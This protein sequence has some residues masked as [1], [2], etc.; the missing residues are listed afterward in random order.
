MSSSIN[1][2]VKIASVLGLPTAPLSPYLGFERFISDLNPG[3]LPAGLRPVGEDVAQE[4][5]VDGGAGRRVPVY[6]QA[7]AQAG[8]LL[9]QE[10]RGAAGPL[11]VCLSLEG[12]LAGAGGP[13]LVLGRH[14]EAVGGEG[15]EAGHQEP[16]LV[17]PGLDLRHLLLAVLP[18]VD[19][20]ARDGVVVVVERDGPGE[21]DRPAADPRDHRAVGRR[22][23]G[24]LHYELHRAGVQPVVD[25]AVVQPAV[26]HAH[27]TEVQAVSVPVQRPPVGVVPLGDLVIE[28]HQPQAPA[29]VGGAGAAV[30]A[31]ADP[32]YEVEVGGGGEATARHRDVA[33]GPRHHPGGGRG[34]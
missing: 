2:V 7:G 18:D 15:L 27:G 11:P 10:G 6:I 28:P 26:L 22:L 24:V 29:G 32:L 1:I 30:A 13:D 33:A 20:V 3:S 31:A 8:D 12:L 23:G 17:P 25:E 4:L 9:L 34:A 16:G 21:E 14:P 19:L 5:P